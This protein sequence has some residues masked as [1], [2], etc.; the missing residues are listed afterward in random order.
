MSEDFELLV[1]RQA[2]CAKSPLWMSALNCLYWVDIM[3]RELH[4]YHRDSGIDEVRV[5]PA[6][7]TA[8]GATRN[9]QLIAAADRGFA[10]LYPGRSALEQV[11][12]V[13]SGDRMNGGAC[14]PAGRFVA[15]T[16]SYGTDPE[17][18]AVF[19]LEGSRARRIIGG[20]S[21]SDGMGWSPDGSILYLADPGERTIWAYDYDVDGGRIGAGTRW[22][23]CADSEGGPQGLAV[24]GTGRVWVAMRRSGR[25]HCYAP[26]GDL[27]TVLWAPTRRITDL[28]FGGR[29]LD[30]MYVTSA[31]FG[32]DE[33]EL[34]ADP[35]AGALFRF[36]PG[37]VGMPSVPWRG[38]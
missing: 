20:L 4:I 19:V 26:T 33:S 28:A 14:D 27:E 21:A 6:V 7:V 15:G 11:T 30:E 36:R 25:I 29:R 24:D 16:L 8:L 38:L 3:R 10:R 22:V 35:Y 2:L 31:C 18:S 13:H 34:S 32:Y 12:A 1:H 23:V 37:T 5:L 9:G 17:R